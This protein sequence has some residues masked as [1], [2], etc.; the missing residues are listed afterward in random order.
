MF[1]SDGN[2]LSRFARLQLFMFF[3]FL[4]L[5]DS[6]TLDVPSSLTASRRTNREVSGVVDDRVL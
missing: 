6:A 4:K 1:F 5:S 2:C 3:F